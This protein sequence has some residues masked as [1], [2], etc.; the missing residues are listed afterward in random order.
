M[1]L[2]KVSIKYRNLKTERERETK[3]HS[4]VNLTVKMSFRDPYKN[5]SLKFKMP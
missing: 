5:C 3:S 2:K 4:I 1:E